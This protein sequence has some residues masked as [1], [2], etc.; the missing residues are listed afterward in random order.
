M[1]DIYLIQLDIFIVAPMRFYLISAL[2]LV[3]LDQDLLVCLH[4][5]Q[6]YVDLAYGIIVRIELTIC[7]LHGAKSCL[8]YGSYRNDTL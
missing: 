1:I 6:I 2:F 3:I 5:D 4:I 8:D 7:L